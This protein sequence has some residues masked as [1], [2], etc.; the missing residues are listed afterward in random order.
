MISKIEQYTFA[1]CS[2]LEKIDMP[3]TL[4]YI[5]YAAFAK[6]VNLKHIDVNNVVKIKFG[7]FAN[8]DQL[9]EKQ[10]NELIYKYGEEIFF[11]SGNNGGEP[12]FV[13][14]NNPVYI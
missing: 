7:T 4:K 5:E 11:T 10:K 13:D 2:N 6:C 9:E 14:I 8:C 1:G 12:Y 3:Y